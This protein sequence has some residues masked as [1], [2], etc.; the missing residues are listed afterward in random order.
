MPNIRILRCARE[1]KLR[2][3]GA[4]LANSQKKKDGAYVVLGA[5]S[6]QRYWRAMTTR[7]SK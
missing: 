7:T 1:K 5:A 3:T 6:L 2:E 4:L